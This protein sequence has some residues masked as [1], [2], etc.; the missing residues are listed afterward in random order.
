ME[1]LN[2][3]D[4][5]FLAVEDAVDHM[6][7]GSVGILEGPAPS[8]RELADVVTTKLPLV[9]RYRQKV[10]TAPGNVGRPLWVDDPHFNIGYHL[11]HTALPSP[12]G[13]G[14]LRNLVGRVMSQQL[15]RHKPL[16][17]M[18]VVEGVGDGRWALVVKVHHAMVDGIA[19]T[20]LLAA[21]LDLEPE[22]HRPEPE[23][24]DPE[25]VPSSAD[26]AWHSLRGL[27]AAPSRFARVALSSAVH[28][29]ALVRRGA[30]FG[31][32]SLRL[33][34]TMG[35]SPPASSLTGPIGPHRRWDWAD[36]SLAD[37]KRIRRSFGGTV[38]D[39]VLTAVTR[40]FRDL[41]LGRGEELGGRVVRSLIPVSL[42]TA[43]ARGVFDNRVSAMFAE[44]PVGIDEPVARLAAVREQMAA[45]K[46]S[47]QIEAS[48]VVTTASGWSP[49]MGAALGA[50]LVVHNQHRIETVTTNVPG[51][52][53]PLFA[54][55][56]KM[57]SLY[58]FV[59]IAGK[60]RVGVAI[61]SYDG[62]VGFGVTGDY[63]GAP[64]IV[65]LA[66]GIEDEIRELVKAGG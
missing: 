25:P 30:D 61:L 50:R 60:V 41:L 51:P 53:F 12:G 20:D 29:R 38:N 33:V 58:P 39:V 37:V 17:E 40:G 24:W 23:P 27:A 10:L 34:R 63:D 2:G 9:P 49:P 54:C 8:A 56:R 64:D 42:R 1:R 55:G 65:V 11:R 32:G 22:P 62:G 66:A 35:T 21:V 48:E 6:H 45:L 59:P 36:A 43:D 47:K 19:G 4:A 7:I 16:W 28:P 57:E 14:E 3:L 18:W 46:E 13:H 26:L 15:D 31:W 5:M 52:Q 44:L